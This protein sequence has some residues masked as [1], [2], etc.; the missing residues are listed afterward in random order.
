[1]DQVSLQASPQTGMHRP[2]QPLHQSGMAVSGST[3]S[4][5]L[6][7]QPHLPVAAIGVA[8]A[9]DACTCHSNR[10]AGPLQGLGCAGIV[11]TLRRRLCIVHRIDEEGCPQTRRACMQGLLLE[12]QAAA[13]DTAYRLLFEGMEQAPLSGVPAAN[14]ALNKPSRLCCR[15]SLHTGLCRRSQCIPCY[16]SMHVS[17]SLCHPTFSQMECCQLATPAVPHDSCAPQV[18]PRAQLL[19]LLGPAHD[20]RQ[21]GELQRTRTLC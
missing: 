20:L 9:K 6:Q 7:L 15:H 8:G 4:S 11:G 1:M 16:L 2:E 17:S 13:A 10:L 3:T 21:E 19:L 14:V 18:Q 5:L 12:W